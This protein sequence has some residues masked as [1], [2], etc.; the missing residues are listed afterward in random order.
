MKPSQGTG[1]YFYR[2]LGDSSFR[3]FLDGKTFSYDDKSKSGRTFI[4]IDDFGYELILVEK[5]NFEKY[6]NSSNPIDILRAQAKH[7]QDYYKGVDPSMVIKDF[8]PASTENPDGSAGRTF[9]LWKKENAAGTEAARQ[10]LV[11]T[12][13][14]DRVVMLSVMVLKASTSED[15]V[16]QQIQR[17]TSRF[18]LI[19]GEQCARVLSAPSTSQ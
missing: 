2:F 10:Y 6:V 3:Y 19:S 12:L 4:F 17:Y 8:G 1:Y 18:D 7:E 11:S 5:S 14:K 16:L 9:Y 13:V 15:D